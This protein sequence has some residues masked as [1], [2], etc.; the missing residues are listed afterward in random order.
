[1]FPEFKTAGNGFL[2]DREVNLNSANCKRPCRKVKNRKVKWAPNLDV[3]INLRANIFMILR[4][5]F[6][7][8]SKCNPAV[9]IVERQMTELWEDRAVVIQV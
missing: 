9:T 4:P 7:P 3:G 5:L 6:A 2:N 8:K 1:M